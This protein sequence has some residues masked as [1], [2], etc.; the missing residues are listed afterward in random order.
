MKKGQKKATKKSPSKFTQHF[1]SEKFASVFLRSLFLENAQK[2]KTHQKRYGL[3]DHFKVSIQ[4]REEP[5][6][7]KVI[8]F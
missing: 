6:E 3:S 4:S 8:F 1:F 2:G 7:D 5:V